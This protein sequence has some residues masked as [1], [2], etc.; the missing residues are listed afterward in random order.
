M[1]VRILDAFAVLVFFND[2]PGAQLVE[3]MIL[4][5]QDGRIDLAMCVVNLGEV[6]YSISRSSSQN[7]AEDYIQQ[8]QSMP[9]EIIDVDWE[10]TR[11]AAQFKTSGN[12]S[13]ADCYVAALAELRKGQIVTGDREFKALEDKIKVIWLK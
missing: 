2:E 7:K 3:D 8:I 11:L 5:A 10:L 6:Y 4:Q 12:I 9:I 1:T 13:Y